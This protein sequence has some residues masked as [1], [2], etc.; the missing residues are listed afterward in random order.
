MNT[1]R[2]WLITG[3]SSGI[4]AALARSVAMKGALLFLTAR[5][6]DLLDEVANDVRAAGAEAVVVPCDLT[7]ARD[8]EAMMHTVLAHTTPDVV[9]HN[10]GR[11]NCSSIEDTSD[12][13]WDSM[14]A[15]NVDAVFRITRAALPAMRQRN[16][17]HFIT[18]SSVAGRMAFPFNAAYV[19]A[20]H[21][22]TGLTAALR[23][24]LA[25]TNI[26]ASILCP[27]GVTTDWA[28][29][30]E[31]GPIGAIFAEGIRLSRT[32]AKERGLPLAPLTPMMSAHD[33]A[34]AV[35]ATVEQGRSSDVFT[36]AGTMEH[37][38]LAVTDRNALDDA[39][40]PLHLGMAQAYQNSRK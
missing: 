37:A 28:S 34:N 21:A 26:Y 5:R 15:L 39:F 36:H 17:G 14:F 30:T 19:A 24:E 8:T 12:E 35:I 6:A 22:V 4:G 9:V 29:A 20:K 1:P 16:S 31:D 27:A 38:A 23:T 10:A 2:T 7:S 40:L 32:I 13:T 11:G 18:I 33:F 3:A 25:G